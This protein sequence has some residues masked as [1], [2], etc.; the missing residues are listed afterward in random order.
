MAADVVKDVRLLQIVELVAAA[1]EAGGRKA[2]V[3]RES[4]K[5]TSSGTSPGTATMRHPVARSRMSLEPRGNRGCPSAATPRP[6]QPVEILAAGA[7]G[8]QPLLPLEQ[9][10][11]DRVLLLAVARPVLLDRVAAPIPPIARSARVPL[12]P[13]TLRTPPR[14]VN[15]GLPTAIGGAT[16]IPLPRAALRRGILH[17]A[18]RDVRPAPSSPPRA[19]RSSGF[20][21]IAALVHVERPVDLDL[22]RMAAAPRVAV[23]AGREPA[24][25]GRVERDREIRASSE[26]T[27]AAS[28]I[29]GAQDGAVA[30]AEHDVGRDL[31]A[32]LAR[33]RR[34]R[35][36]VDQ[37]D[38]RRTP[39]RYRSTSRRSAW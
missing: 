22:Q 2:P 21:A 15:R 12:P 28:T 32:G 11:P 35:M 18:P 23:M 29:S 13:C 19:G 26:T 14:R 3:A 24:G 9:Q 37:E 33:R 27:R 17:A 39:P 38:S 4:A 10:A 25:I 34:H 31:P 5:K 20:S 1:D 30:V 16:L 6:A 8:Q 36:A 7:P